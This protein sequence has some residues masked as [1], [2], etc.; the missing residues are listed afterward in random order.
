[1]IAISLRSNFFMECINTSRI[2][3]SFATNRKRPHVKLST[4]GGAR[5]K[6]SGNG[7]SPQKGKDNGKVNGSPYKG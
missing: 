7:T 2:Q 5:P 6:Q 4:F 3:S 1:M